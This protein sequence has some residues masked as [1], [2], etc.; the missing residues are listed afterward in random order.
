M[1]NLISIAKRLTLIGCKYIIILLTFLSTKRRI[2]PKNSMQFIKLKEKRKEDIVESALKVF[3]EKGYAGATIN[4]IVKKAKCSH[5][6]FYHYFKS[7]KEIFNEV[8][9]TR[10]KHMI[11][12]L[13]KVL[14]EKSNYVDKLRKMTEYIF[15]NM[16][17]DEIFAYRYYFFVSTIF[18]KAESGELPPKCDKK[19]PPHIRMHSFFEEGVKQGEFRRDFTPADCAKLYNSIIQGATLNFILCPKEFKQSFKFPVIDFIVDIFKKETSL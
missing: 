11:Y 9:E 14:E 18:A 12:F 7:K 10:G 8:S 5:G 16:K 6:L 1:N 13:D 15:N 17:K 2:M 19:V 4:D 3:C